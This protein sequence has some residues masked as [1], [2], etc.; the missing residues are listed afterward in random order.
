MMSI[1]PTLTNTGQHHVHADNSASLDP[2]LELPKKKKKKKK[3]RREDEQEPGEGGDGPEKKKKRNKRR[4]E[5]E[6]DGVE[7]LAVVDPALLDP[8]PPSDAPTKKKSKKKNKGKQPATLLP[9]EPDQ[10][11]VDTSNSQASTAA[12][13][14]AIVA[15]ATGTPDSPLPQDA[16]APQYQL[17]MVPHPS[18]QPY[19]PYSYQY[20]YGAP[21]YMQPNMMQSQTM[22]PTPAGLPFSELSFGSNEDVLRALQALDMSKITN[23][24]KTLGEAAAAANGQAFTGEQI[25]ATPLGQ[26]PVGSGAILGFASQEPNTSTGHRRTLDMTLPGAEYHTR[27]DHAYLLANKWLNAG[28]LSELVRTEGTHHLF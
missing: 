20:D 5:P 22:F 14:S 19:M 26:I 24:L 12:L 11:Q 3:R 23:V 8:S 15:A 27:A 2:S 1:A 25:Q 10:R 9:T 17:H 4:A 7:I 16:H 28:K 13:I 21:P 6:E 18:Q